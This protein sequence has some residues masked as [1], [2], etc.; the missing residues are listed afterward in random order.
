M[1]FCL[2][3]IR[4]AW[5]WDVSTTTTGPGWHFCRD[6]QHVLT[7]TSPQVQSLTI[8]SNLTKPHLR[9]A[10]SEALGSIFKA[11]TCIL[12][13][14][15]WRKPVG[16]FW[17]RYKIKGNYDQQVS[18]LILPHRQFSPTT[19][20]NTLSTPKP[21]NQFICHSRL[22]PPMQLMRRYGWCPAHQS[23]HAVLT[24]WLST[25]GALRL[26]GEKRE[27]EELA[28]SLRPH[29]SWMQAATASS[30][31]WSSWDLSTEMPWHS[32]SAS[33]I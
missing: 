13:S 9:W 20:K 19:R 2:S 11:S 29:G 23:R 17:V 30:H 26:C 25:K 7:G 28:M 21:S 16:N 10:S 15:I 8:R 24:F 27:R 18:T 1:T 31:S 4:G 5:L 3:I 33:F 32:T 6:G 12:T 14:T 22:S